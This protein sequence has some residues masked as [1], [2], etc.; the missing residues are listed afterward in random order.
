MKEVFNHCEEKMSKSVHHLEIEYGSVSAGRANPQVLDKVSVDYYGTP[1]PI[2]QMAAVAVS[3]ARILTVT[4]WDASTIREMEKAIQVADIGIN[5]Q[6]DGKTIRLVFPQ[7]TEERRKEIVKTI[8]KMAEDAKVAI[9]AVRRDAIE[10]LKGMK[11]D[12]VISEDDLK[13]GEKHTQELTDKYC[14]EVDERLAKKEKEI[15]EI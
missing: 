12:S 15:L 4:P 9:R 5:P 11:K 6:N 10:K 13:H 2:N 3:E 8:H 7:P 14:K 1:T